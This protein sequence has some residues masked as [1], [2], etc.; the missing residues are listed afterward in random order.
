MH[1]SEGFTDKN[2]LFVSV[3]KSHVFMVKLFTFKMSA[4]DAKYA[5]SFWSFSESI[6]L[7]FSMIRS[8]GFSLFDVDLYALVT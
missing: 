7:S 5:F 6:I 8:Y 2:S 1:I 4:I 3:S